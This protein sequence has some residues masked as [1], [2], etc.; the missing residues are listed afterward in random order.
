MKENLLKF[1]DLANEKERQMAIDI[2]TTQDEL[3]EQRTFYEQ[4][5]NKIDSEKDKIAE[6]SRI[7]FEQSIEPLRANY[8]VSQSQIEVIKD[9]IRALQLSFLALKEDIVQDVKLVEKQTIEVCEQQLKG[10]EAVLVEQL[11]LAEIEAINIEKRFNEIR[12]VLESEKQLLYRRKAELG[13]EV[14]FL[15]IQ[16]FKMEQQQNMQLAEISQLE[17][18]KKVNEKLLEKEI[19]DFDQQKIE[20]GKVFD[21]LEAEFEE[22]RAKKSEEIKAFRDHLEKGKDMIR[23]LDAA[24]S[25]F[26]E[27]T[28]VVEQRNQI[29]V[30]NLEI[31]FNN[32]F[33]SK[34]GGEGAFGV[35]GY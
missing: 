10:E 18:K 12:Q 28:K 35:G 2:A 29:M 31:G 8:T 16:K 27:E 9:E 19:S 21:V 20:I 30:N 33:Q 25:Q 13:T 6:E 17:D 3:F 34:F 11:Q 32:A 23:R 4:L 26:T 14:D 7:N 24:I 15:N 22:V 1:S 5:S